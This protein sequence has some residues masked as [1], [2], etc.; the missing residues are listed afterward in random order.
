MVKPSCAA[1]S[2]SISITDCG[3]SY[4]MSLSMNMNMPLLATVARKAC[5]TSLSRS[6]GS[7]DS[8]ANCTGSPR[9][10]GREGC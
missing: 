3:A 8:I 5:D 9:A 10:P 1:L 2:R 7:V 4:F 6:A